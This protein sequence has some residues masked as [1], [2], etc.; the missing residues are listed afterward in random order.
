MKI[1]EENI[2]V[3]FNFF[4]NHFELILYINLACLIFGLVLFIT[5][6]LSDSSFRSRVYALF[7]NIF[8]L[9]VITALACM[10]VLSVS[11]YWANYRLPLKE[12]KFIDQIVLTTQ[13]IQ[14]E[15]PLYYIQGNT[16]RSMIVGRRAEKEI[17]EGKSPLREYHFSPDGRFI[18]AAGLRELYLVENA[19][20]RVQIID[21]LPLEE[22]TAA[23]GEINNNESLRGVIRG[24]RWSPDSEKFCYET[25]LWTPF[26]SHEHLYVYSLTDLK[27]I[28]INSPLR[29]ISSLYWDIQAEN[30]YYLYN[31]AKDTSVS[32]YSYGIKVFRIPIE[33]S[34]EF[35]SSPGPEFVTEI[36][37]EKSSLPLDHLKLR[38]VELFLKGDELSF[39][40]STHKSL[41]ASPALQSREINHQILM[42]AVSEKGK[43]VGVDRDDYL[44]YISN[45]WFRKR[46]FKIPREPVVSDVPHYPYKGG[47]PVIYNIRWL[48]GG[49]YVILEHQY[50]GVFIL[51]PYSG[52]IGHVIGLRGEAIGWFKEI[53]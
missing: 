2:S 39:E 50:M 36:P 19:T 27:K 12:R 9:S 7:A 44:Y 40:R 18:L 24:I 22:P 47:E 6:Q 14:L 48:P 45:K 42:S 33:R 8:S 25:S 13:G 1:F 4:S 11:V 32:S 30:L 52:K 16:L 37:D 34:G 46:L 28:E 15:T 17:L 26:S 23:R 21:S 53:Q 29:R 38:G 3:F 41:F 31:E 51:D 49:R 10:I 43:V 5:V 35:I 20:Q